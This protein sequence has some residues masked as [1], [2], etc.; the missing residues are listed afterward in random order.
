MNRKKSFNRPAL[1]GHLFIL[2][3]ASIV[4][5]IV[6]IIP[7]IISVGLFVYRLERCIFK[8]FIYRYQEFHRY[9]LLEE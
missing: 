2:G 5:L 1:W 4:F 6:I 3:P 9:F 7:F 8:Y